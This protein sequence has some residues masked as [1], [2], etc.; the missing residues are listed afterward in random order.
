MLIRAKHK[1]VSLQTYITE[2]LHL[3]ADK[4]RYTNLTFR[5]RSGWIFIY[6]YEIK[7]QVIVIFLIQT[8]VI[9]AFA[10]L[11]VR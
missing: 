7:Y 2:R 10:K 4:K 11:S 3:N 5:S 6:V 1:R 8:Q 9:H